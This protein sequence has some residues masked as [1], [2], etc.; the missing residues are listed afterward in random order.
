MSVVVAIKD[1]DTVWVGCDSQVSMGYTKGT[2]KLNKK[3]WKPEKEEGIVMGVVGSVRDLDILS[4]EEDWI[5]EIVKIKNE[6]NY[7][8]M[9]RKIVPKIFKTLSNF[10]RMKN[11]KGIESIES[12]IIFTHKDKLFSINGD[13]SVIE[14]DD[15]LADGS[16]YRL[17]LGAWN[18]LKNKDIPIKDK[19]VQVI[20]A[21]CESDLYVN[22]PIVLMNTKTEEVE[23]VE[24]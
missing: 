14:S 6:F 15:I 17:C 20:K 13:G 21:A 4:T 24:K 19:L 22:Y 16:G 23:I 18:S 2:L 10:G 11:D 1:K 12:S 9:V 5:E 7:K 3:I 8:Y